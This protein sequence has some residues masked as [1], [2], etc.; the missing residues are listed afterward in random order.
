MKRRKDAQTYSLTPLKEFSTRMGA[1]ID[2]SEYKGKL[3]WAQIT[4]QL[5]L[6]GEL[7]RF[8]YHVLPLSIAVE[9]QNHDVK[10]FVAPRALLAE[11]FLISPCF[12]DSAQLSKV[13]G[14]D[15]QAWQ[16]LCVSKVTLADRN[17]KSWGA[18]RPELKVKL[19]ELSVGKSSKANVESE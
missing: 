19:F 12:D 10:N 3:L 9:L 1:P 2:V 18:F 5:S 13:L 17:P 6:M 4:P 8:V 16:E 7:A 15:P 11:G 14:N